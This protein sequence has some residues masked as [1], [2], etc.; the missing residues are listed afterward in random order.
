VSLLLSLNNPLNVN[1]LTGQLLSAPAIWAKPDG[2]RTALSFMG[3]FHSAAIKYVERERAAK[4]G[5][6]TLVTPSTFESHIPFEEWIRTVTKGV[7]ENSQRSHHPLVFGGL[8][9]GI[10]SQ[11]EDILSSRLGVALQSA[12]V[13]ATN[14]AI[15]EG[16]PRDESSLLEVVLA[17]NHAFTYLSDLERSKL[18]YD[19]LLPVLMNSMLHFPD[20][21][22]SGYF[23][24][25]A[26]GDLRQVSSKFFNWS[27]GSGSYRQVE[28]ILTGPLISNLGP[29]SRLVAHTLQQVHDPWLVLSAVED[30]ADFS[31]RLLTQ[32]RQNKLSEID[33]SEEG[34]FLHE[35]A[36][37]ET[38][39]T[40]WRLLRATLFAVVIILR[41]AVGR[42]VGDG[43]LAST[44]SKFC[45]IF[46]CSTRTV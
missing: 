35:E 9:I 8:L 1:L 7:D 10:G 2:L 3:V 4:N 38:L 13:K 24:G 11:D 6:S 14:L 41:S 23:L 28:R 5:K 17:L 30:L 31:R 19:R 42:T 20:G 37:R 21:L 27:K 40:L 22:M 12:F 44:D 16:Y 25:A 43:V 45:L 15:Q 29:L 46:G 33:T 36:R 32:W 39:P 34:M 18:D 26:D